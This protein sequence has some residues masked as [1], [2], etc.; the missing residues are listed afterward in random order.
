MTE[1][2]LQYIWQFQHYNINQLST[3]DGQLITIVHPGTL[4]TNQGP[5]FLNAKINI[6]GTLWAGSVEL[7]LFSS[8][9]K[10]HNH[11]N[12]KN[13][14]N[15]ILHVVWQED[16]KL[17]VAFPTLILQDRIS[18]IL[19]NKYG[20]MM[21]NPAFVPCY[22]HLPSIRSITLTSWKERLLV[23]RLQTKASYIHSLLLQ[24]NFHWEETFWW[25]ISRNFGIT[26]NSEAFEAIARSIP[27]N[28]LAKHKQQIIQLEAILF[29]QAGLLEK[30]FTEDYPVLLKK[31][32]Q[33]LQKKYSLR[34]A[35]VNLL[36]MRMRPANF[37]TI[38]LAQLSAL[39]MQSQHLFSTILESRSITEIESL[40]AV[41]ANDYWHYHYNFEDE[42]SFK[43]KVLGRQMIHN[44]IINTIVPMLF[45]H[46]FYNNNEATKNKALMWLEQVSA[47]QNYI[48]KGFVK[49]GIQNKSAFDSQALIQM[50]NEYCNQKRCLQCAVGNLILKS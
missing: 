12:D 15:V 32:Y 30:K 26:L 31:E 25:M 21:G 40:L 36:F 1:Q 23:E 28:I 49:L 50:K 43:P 46:G 38:R 8:Q 4:N 20:D 37:P 27:I 14:K 13:Y 5:D 17:D 47:E 34:V 2:L 24:N 18:M 7:H 41:T 10:T 42:A 45:T 9:W 39:V 6:A 48:T 3:T 44:I 19:L 16:E 22:K 11:G 33:F 35:G 29:G